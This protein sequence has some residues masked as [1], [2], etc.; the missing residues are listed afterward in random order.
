MGA[1]VQMTQASII[2]CS[3]P[4]SG[5]GFCGFGNAGGLAAFGNTWDQ[6]STFKPFFRATNSVRDAFELLDTQDG[7]QAHP[8]PTSCPPHRPSKTALLQMSL[9]GY[10]ST[11]PTTCPSSTPTSGDAV[12]GQMRAASGHRVV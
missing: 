7:W 6:T 10:G 12:P 3:C 8:S 1:Q 9:V 2:N 11:Q 5:H 4:G